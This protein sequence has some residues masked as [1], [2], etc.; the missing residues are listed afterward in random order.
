MVSAAVRDDGAA[1]RSRRSGCAGGSGPRLLWTLMLADVLHAPGRD[2]MA[3]QPSHHS[4]PAPSLVAH[5]EFR[6]TG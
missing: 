2:V 3:L 4:E 5:A 6:E 1:S